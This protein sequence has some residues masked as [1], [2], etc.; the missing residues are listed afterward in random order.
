MH[1]IAADLSGGK[2]N[3]RTNVHLDPDLWSS[4]APRAEGW[5]AS[6]GQVG[7]AQGHLRRQNVTVG[8]VFL[9]FGWFR[10]TEQHQ[11]TWRYVP[12]A[13]EIHSLFGWLQV[14]EVIALDAK[15]KT[16]V[17]LHDHPHVVHAS[18]IGDGNTLYVADDRLTINGA[19]VVVAG[20]GGF[21]RWSK[22]LQLTA[23]GASTKSI[24]RMPKWIEPKADGPALS[25]HADP[26]RWSTVDGLPHLKSVAKGQEFVREVDSAA[27]HRWLSQLIATHA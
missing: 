21:T 5:R 27:G 4:A 20:A 8:D 13:P 1:S 7:S 16:P 3:A 19:D 23:P 17:W 6:L 2:I 9:F 26:E 15:S 22:G 14:G 10:R 24:W 18:G 25:Y 12:G 11:G